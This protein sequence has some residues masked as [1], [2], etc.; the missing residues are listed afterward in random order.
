MKFFF[1]Y[2][3]NFF[4]KYKSAK[5]LLI[6]YIFNSLN[7]PD[8]MENDNVDSHVLCFYFMFSYPNTRVEKKSARFILMFEI[9]QH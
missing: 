9:R 3:N 6:S 2:I 1:I 8:L 5:V 7:Q 4:T